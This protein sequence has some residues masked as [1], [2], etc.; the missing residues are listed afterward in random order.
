[1][2][3]YSKHMTNLE[4]RIESSF[5]RLIGI[6][7]TPLCEACRCPLDSETLDCPYC[8]EAEAN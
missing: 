6:D 1:M 3:M 4:A 5:Q 2:I 7:A 8:N